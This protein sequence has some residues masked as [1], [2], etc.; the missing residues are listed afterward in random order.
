MSRMPNKFV[1]RATANKADDPMMKS[2]IFL[3]CATVTLA[4]LMS[5]CLNKKEPT[6][7]STHPDGWNSESSADFHGKALLSKSLSLAG[8]QSCHGATYQGGSSQVSCFSSQCHSLFPHPEG[9]ADQNSANFHED[10]ISESLNWDILAC[11]KCHGS[12]YSGEGFQEKNCLTCH[13]ALDGPEAC[14]TCHGSQNNPAPPRDLRGN[15]A[16]TER[17]VGAHQAHLT[18]STWTTFRQGECQTCHIKPGRYADMGHIDESPHSEV[19]FDTLATFDGR[20]NPVWNGPDASCS[21][22]YC[23]GGFEFKQSESSFPWA[24][25]D[26]LMS[27]NRPTLFWKFVNSG[28]ALCGSCHGLPPRGH[29]PAATCNSCHNRVVSADFQI[30]NKSLHINGKV[31]VF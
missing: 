5:G 11:Q 19:I 27:G 13:T 2:R 18:G 25:A 28:Q 9:F 15:T 3:A 10:F 26:S 29:I 24:Y 4:F 31:D 21:D 20:E 30:I 23:H 22:V 7:V 12:D 17:G 1:N 16:T 6:E 8:C 14:N